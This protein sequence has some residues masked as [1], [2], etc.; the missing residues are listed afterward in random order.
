MRVFKPEYIFHWSGK[1]LANLGDYHPCYI[2]KY[3]SCESHIA[4]VT[5]CCSTIYIEIETKYFIN[6]LIV[7][8][9]LLFLMLA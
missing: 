2:A 6:M 1:I 8:F 7:L 4:D 3:V 9:F 5:E